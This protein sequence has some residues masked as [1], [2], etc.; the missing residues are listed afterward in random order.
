MATRLLKILFEFFYLYVLYA[1]WHSHWR[2]WRTGCN[3]V[4]QHR[5]AKNQTMGMAPLPQAPTSHQL[6]PSLRPCHKSKEQIAAAKAVKANKPKCRH[7]KLA[8]VMRGTLTMRGCGGESWNSSGSVVRGWGVGIAESKENALAQLGSSEVIIATIEIIQLVG[9]ST[10]AAFLSCTILYV[11]AISGCAFYG[12]DYG[13]LFL[14]LWLPPSFLY[15]TQFKTKWTSG[16]GHDVFANIKCSNHNVA[17]RS[18]GLRN[19]FNYMELWEYVYVH[20]Y[21]DTYI[22]T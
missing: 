1:L 14:L 8:G 10:R 7:N 13:Q 3:N 15:Y 17:A 21:I 18:A 11:H 19:D 9:G 6:L 4:A 20:R 12:P 5:T 2:T 22:H 16:N